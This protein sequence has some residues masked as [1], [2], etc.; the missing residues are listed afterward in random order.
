ML[1]EHM[2]LAGKRVLVTGGTTGIGRAIVFML[3]DEGA[4]VLTFGRDEKVLQETIETAR[5]KKGELF[6]LSADVASEQDVVRIYSELD[7]KLGGIDILVANAGIAGDG[8]AEASEKDWRYV[9]E[10]NLVGYMSC[11]KAAI[12]RMRAGPGGQLVFIGSISAELKSPGTSVYAT[13]KAGIEAFAETLRK[14]VADMNIRVS[15]IQPGSVKSDMQE[16]SPEEQELAI[17]RHE[18]LAAEEIAEAVQ[19]I[20]T[21]AARCDVVNLR[22]EP[23]LED[24]SG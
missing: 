24:Y 16:S 5:K 2:S 8:L 6:G 10:T 7:A 15:S 11:A 20:I 22:I 9:V 14:E 21:R 13:T 3:M 4:R 1:K 19:F 23:R 17:T 12:E 18:M